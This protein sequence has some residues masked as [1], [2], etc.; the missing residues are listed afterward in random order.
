MHKNSKY[1][2]S[3]YP[4]Q[5]IYYAMIPRSARLF[6]TPQIEYWL[7]LDRGL[8]PRDNLDNPLDI[9]IIVYSRLKLHERGTDQMDRCIL[10]TVHP[11]VFV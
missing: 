2:T 1:R 10:R 8:R 5:L 4:A 7:W 9:T 6:K 3:V 11:V